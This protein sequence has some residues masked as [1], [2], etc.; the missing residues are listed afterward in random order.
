MN[1]L[2]KDLIS[3]EEGGETFVYLLSILKYT[4]E[5][6]FQKPFPHPL[7]HPFP[8]PRPGDA[9]INKGVEFETPLAT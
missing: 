4:N 3:K 7:L 8:Q 5:K 6:P 2:T 9:S 1:K